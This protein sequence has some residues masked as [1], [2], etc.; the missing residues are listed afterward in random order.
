LGQQLVD[1]GMASIRP[2]FQPTWKNRRRLTRRQYLR[3]GVGCF[4]HFEILSDGGQHAYSEAFQRI[5]EVVHQVPPICDLECGRGAAPG[6]AGVDTIPV[7]TDDFDTWM[8]GKP[9]DERIR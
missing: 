9:V 2:L 7:A 4:F 8:S 3:R 5:S 1:F 6:S